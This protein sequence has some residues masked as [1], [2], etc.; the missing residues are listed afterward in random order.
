MTP[1]DRVALQTALHADR[2]DAN[3]ARERDYRRPSP[4]REAT[5]SVPDPETSTSS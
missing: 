1:S 3:R 4:G 5:M 2:T